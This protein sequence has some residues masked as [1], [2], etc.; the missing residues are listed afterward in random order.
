MEDLKTVYKTERN[1][2][3]YEVHGIWTGYKIHFIDGKEVPAEEVNKILGEKLD[4]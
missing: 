2:H 4:D 1:G 3:V